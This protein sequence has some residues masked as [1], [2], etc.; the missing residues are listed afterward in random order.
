M[1]YIWQSLNHWEN[2]GMKDYQQQIE[3][4]SPF[5]TPEFKLPLINDDN[6]L[7]NQDELQDRIRFM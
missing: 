3:T 2:D 4:L 6:N 7:L 5:L 1:Y